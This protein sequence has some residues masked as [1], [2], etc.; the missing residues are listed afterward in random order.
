MEDIMRTARIRFTFTMIE[1]LVTIAI[2]IILASLLLP[3]LRSAKNSAMG[4][5]CLNN[6]KQLGTAHHFYIDES[7]YVHLCF[8]RT[9]IG[10]SYHWYYGS[11]CLQSY[12]NYPFTGFVNFADIPV[13]H[14]PLDPNW[15]S[16]ISAGHVQYISYAQNLYTG[17]GDQVAGPTKGPIH[18][19]KFQTPSQTF[20]M[21][22]G[23]EFYCSYATGINVVHGSAA[24]VLYTDGH[25]QKLGLVNIGDKTSNPTFWKP[26]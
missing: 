26:F 5:T 2:I 4:L 3:A 25:A 12:I 18:I 14:C 13:L 20:L 19:G 6:L 17:G 22:D 11:N 16:P 24:N 10:M 23:L 8:R 9:D 7:S 21:I 1:L 15:Q